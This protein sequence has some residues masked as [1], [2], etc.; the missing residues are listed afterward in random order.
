MT[1]KASLGLAAAD[2]DGGQATGT[3]LPIS[4]D[5]IRETITGELMESFGNAFMERG[6]LMEEETRSYYEFMTDAACEPIGF[7]RDGRKGTST[8]AALRAR[9]A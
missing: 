6:R 3:Q 7:I 8:R 1:L 2:D 9:P 4:K 5:Q